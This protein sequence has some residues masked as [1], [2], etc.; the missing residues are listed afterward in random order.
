MELWS[1]AT[2]PLDGPLDI[3][4]GTLGAMAQVV[5]GETVFCVESLAWKLAWKLG[6]ECQF[7]IFE[8]KV[9][10]SYLS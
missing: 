5:G 6:E 3:G 4:D 2:H 1:L 7:Q 9:C 10:E 8:I